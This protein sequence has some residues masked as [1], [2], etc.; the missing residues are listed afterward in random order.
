MKNYLA[1]A[2]ATFVLLD[3]GAL[4]FSYSIARQVEK[5]AVAINLAGR[6]RMLSQRVTKAA[7]LATQPAR[8]ATQ[9]TES[10]AEVIQAY[11]VFRRT[12]LA[13]AEGGETPGGDGRSVRLEPVE[14]HAA[15]LVAEVRSVLDSWPKAPTDY[16]DLERF[17]Q[18]MVERNGV[19]LEA[20]N[21]LTTVLEQQSVATVSRLR[22]A[23]SAVFILSFCN[24]VFI[25]LGMHRARLHAEKESVT[26]ALT[27]IL[28]RG[29]FYTAL[30]TA[31][32]RRNAS[33]TPLAVL[34]LDLNGFK[35]I[36]DTY[37]HAAGDATL[38]EVALRLQG[39]SSHG[40]TC[41]RL[42]GDEFAIICPGLAPEQLLATSQQLDH[43]LS[44]IATGG[45]TVSASIG[46]T[47]VEAHQSADDVIAAADAKMYS[48]KKTQHPARGHR[49]K[50]R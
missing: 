34:L 9:R 19:I 1:L 50:Q 43:L 46:W 44:G 48:I 33:Y 49:D 4:A 32:A 38:R 26:D 30:H 39:L 14:G 20:M 15:S 25:L 22:I 10:A 27:G 42:G 18:F 40:W 28:N 12:L 16:P 35:A 7:L 29:G 8:S 2:V 36:N 17:S 21:Q 11:W 31:L 41:G 6:Q 47:S 37:G 13:F 23:Q 5:D 45:H 3:L 24:F